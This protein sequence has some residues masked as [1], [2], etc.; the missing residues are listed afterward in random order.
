MQTIVGL[1]CLRSRRCTVAIIG[2]LLALFLFFVSVMSTRW[3]NTSAT[4]TMI[5]PAYSSVDSLIDM[6]LLN[7]MV[8][9]EEEVKS[10][11]INYQD[12]SVVIISVA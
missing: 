9:Q 8:L 5:M 10:S 2:A 4:M 12:N 1:S 11:Q 6:V 7:L 3:M